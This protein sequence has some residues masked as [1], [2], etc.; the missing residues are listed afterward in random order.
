M[1]NLTTGARCYYNNDSVSFDSVYGPL[2]NWYA[3]NDNNGICP[4]GWHVPSYAE[5]QTAENYYGGPDL[6][7]G[8]MKETGTAHWMGPNTGAT[9]SSRFSGLPGGMRD[10]TN[11]FLY[12]CENSYWWTAS[13]LEPSS[14]FVWNT[15]FWYSSINVS[16]DPAPKNYGFS[17]RCVKDITSGLID[18][19][20]KEQFKIFPNP[21]NDRLSITCNRDQD[22]TIQIFNITGGCVM[23]KQINDL[24]EEIDISSLSKGAYIIEFLNADC[25]IYMKL[26]KE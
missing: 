16:H 1:V 12:I 4:E 21:V 17:L 13:E 19:I 5:W 6:A 26:I 2:F 20:E 7:G 14:P 15:F 10:P 8:E 9:N 24:S 3:V 11:N 18:V 22:F 23:Q 25:R